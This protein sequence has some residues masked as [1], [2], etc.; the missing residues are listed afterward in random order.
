MT[1]RNHWLSVRLFCLAAFIMATT[2]AAQPP[3]LQQEYEMAFTLAT[4]GAAYDA[5][6]LLFEAARELPGDDPA[7]VEA[8]IGPAQLLVFI[9]ASLTDFNDWMMFLNHVVDEENHVTD[10]L[11][12]SGLRAGMP[13]QAR[14]F[15]GY[16]GL[17]TTSQEEHQAVKVASLFVRA[18]PYW[19]PNMPQNKNEYHSAVAEMVLRYPNLSLSRHVVEM[20]VWR[21]VKEASMAGERDVHLFRDVLYAGGR[22]EPILAVSAGLRA[23][24]QALP[25]LNLK[26][27]DDETISQLADLLN[28]ARD[29]DVRYALL[30]FIDKLELTTKWRALLRGALQRL[31]RPMPRTADEA[32]ARLIL[33]HFALMDGNDGLVRAHL[34]QLWPRGPFPPTPERNLYVESLWAAHEAARYFTRYGRYAPAEQAYQALAEHFPETQAAQRALDAIAALREDPVAASLDAI[35]HHARIQKRMKPDFDKEALLDHIIDHADSAPLRQALLEQKQ[36]EPE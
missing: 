12:A 36:R 22:E 13:G 14:R 1:S 7:L 19:L 2:A 3:P 31:S 23:L 9:A 29:P 33:I 8:L 6:V 35:E 24:K 5:G 27:I 20:S 34:A 21:T 15:L 32:L 26:D 17:K 10:R 16:H 18:A 11:I 30:C 25:S 28:E 4:S